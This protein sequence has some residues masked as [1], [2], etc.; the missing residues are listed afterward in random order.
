[1]KLDIRESSTLLAALRLYQDV[2]LSRGLP[3]QIYDIASNGDEIDALNLNEI[4][5]LC[6]RINT[7][8]S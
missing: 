7:I 6:E 2:V 5:E 1:M 3:D 4:D 8:E